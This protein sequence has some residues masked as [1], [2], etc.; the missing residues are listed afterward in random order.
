MKTRGIHRRGCG[1]QD[2][3]IRLEIHEQVLLLVGVAAVKLL[4]DLLVASHQ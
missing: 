3:L 4:E 2:L 1:P